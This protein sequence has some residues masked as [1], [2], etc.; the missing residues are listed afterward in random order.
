MELMRRRGVMGAKEAPEELY[1]VGTDIILKYIG[2]KAGS[3]KYAN[4]VYNKVLDTSGAYV[5]STNT[6]ASEAYMEVDPKFRY[7]KT[8]RGGESSGGRIYRLAYYDKNYQFI[9]S[10]IHNTLY[11]VDLAALPNNAR[12]AR[13]STANTEN[14]WDLAIVR[15][16]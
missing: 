15:S 13:V 11:D 3:N 1:P 8:V 16:A 2:L 7:R 10:V 6:A 5:D 12:Y 14:N 4:F 9:S